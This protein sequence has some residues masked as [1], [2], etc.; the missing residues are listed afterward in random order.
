MDQI[1]ADT[2]G[3]AFYHTNG[4]SDA[5]NRIAD[6]GSYFYTISYTP[7]NAATDGRFRKIRV[8]LTSGKYKLAYRRGYFALDENDVRKH[9]S[10]AGDDPLRDMMGPGMPESSE[11]PLAVHVQ[12]EVIHVGATPVGDNKK[13]DGLKCHCTRY[14][15]GYVIGRIVSDGNGAITERLEQSWAVAAF[16]RTLKDLTGF[17]KTA[18]WAPGLSDLRPC[19]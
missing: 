19:A 12:T 11:I 7:T 6:L 18:S 3:Q 15:L 2:G 4:L 10:K 9:D 5:L 14:S 13:L 16:M 1:A 17:S 8:R